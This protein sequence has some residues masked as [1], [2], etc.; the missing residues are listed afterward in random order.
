MQ[1]VVT[2]P[3]T[4]IEGHVSLR[5]PYETGDFFKYEVLRLSLVYDLNEGMD[6]T[7][8]MVTEA[9]SRPRRSE[10]FARRCAG[11]YRGFTYAETCC[12]KYVGGR[13]V[14]YVVCDDG[15]STP[16]GANRGLDSGVIV[17]GYLDLEAVFLEPKVKAHAAREQ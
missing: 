12:L 8:T 9:I 7:G 2:Q 3:G 17:Q 1:L 14:G 5:G 11:D 6:S 13:N 15:K 10:G 4:L 16:V